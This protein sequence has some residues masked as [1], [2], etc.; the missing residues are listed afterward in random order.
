[1]IKSQS[2]PRTY[3]IFKK[4]GT[5]KEVTF[6]SVNALLKSLSKYPTE[7]HHVKD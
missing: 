4:N 7:P 5:V 3:L 2:F 6:K 1:M